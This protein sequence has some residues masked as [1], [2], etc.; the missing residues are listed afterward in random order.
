MIIDQNNLAEQIISRAEKVQSMDLDAITIADASEYC[1][2]TEDLAIATQAYSMRTLLMKSFLMYSI[3]CAIQ[4]IVMFKAFDVN[5]LLIT[6]ANLAIAAGISAWMTYKLY[7]CSTVIE[8]I[9]GS[10]DKFLARVSQ[11]GK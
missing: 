10:Y 2:I 11:K 5:P 4:T 8:N 3:V 1:A 6:F 7:L 9:L